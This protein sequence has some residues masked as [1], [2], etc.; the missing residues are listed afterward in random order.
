M[1]YWDF[2][3]PG[4]LL[5]CSS[6]LRWRGPT[7]ILA[8]VSSKPL[9]FL[10]HV[11]WLSGIEHWMCPMWL[12]TW[13]IWEY[14]CIVHIKITCLLFHNTDRHLT[15][16]V[17]VQSLVKSLKYSREVVSPWRPRTNNFYLSSFRW[18]CG[19]CVFIKKCHKYPTPHSL[20][21]THAQHILLQRQWDHTAT[22][23]EPTM[24]SS[25]KIVTPRE[26]SQV[27]W[28]WSSKYFKV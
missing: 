10:F 8:A 11:T 13:D 19:V 16:W 26:S 14:F 3:F 28:C 27:C 24:C 20:S 1:H 6:A 7:W 4:W 17:N 9:L 21:H 5:G 2:G 18:Q 23:P 22:T 25:L 12:T 15:Y